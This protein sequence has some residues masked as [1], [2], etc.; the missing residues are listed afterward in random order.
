[1]HR[2]ISIAVPCPWLAGYMWSTTVPV[3]C[4][5]MIGSSSLSMLHLAAES[6]PPGQTILWF[7]S[8]RGEAKEVAVI[9]N[10]LDVA[11][12]GESAALKLGSYCAFFLPIFTIGL[13]SQAADTDR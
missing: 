12:T 9:G 4:K 13:Y 3:L 5:Q 7:K 11:K 1:M 2:R 10:R 6:M 8:Q